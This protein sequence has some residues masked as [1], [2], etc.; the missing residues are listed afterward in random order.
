MNPGWDSGGGETPLLPPATRSHPEPA[1]SALPPVAAPT[2]TAA[3]STAASPATPAPR[4]VPE[5]TVTTRVTTHTLNSS[6]AAP[7]FSPIQ[8]RVGSRV[9]RKC[10]GPNSLFAHFLQC[11]RSHNLRQRLLNTFWYIISTIN[12]WSSSSISYHVVLCVRLNGSRGG[13]CKVS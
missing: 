1:L 6:A 10:I 7:S 12:A 2:A 13:D 3:T 11:H 4:V 9:A 8:H 5:F